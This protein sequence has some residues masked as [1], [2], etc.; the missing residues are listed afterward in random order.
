[1]VARL[2]GYPVQYNKAVV[3]RNAFAHEAGIHQHGVLEDRETYEIIDASTV[4]QE[5]AQIV[6]G[7]HSGRHAFADSLA[8][9]GLH[10]QGD[11]LNQAFTRFK[12]L[13]DRKVQITEA[14]LEAIVA[15]ELGVGVVHRY[16]IVSLEVRGG[17]VAQPSATVVLADEERGGKVE[18]DGSGNGMIDAAIEA[19]GKATGVSGTVLDFK[20]SS[21]TGGGDAL[22]DVVIQ[23]EVDGLKA[24]GR[25]CR[26]RRGGGL[27]ACLPEC[28]QQDRALARASRPAGEGRRA[29]TETVNLWTGVACERPRT[30]RPDPAPGRGLRGPAR[31]P[32]RG[33]SSRARPRH[34][35]RLAALVGAQRAPGRRRGGGRLLVDHARRGAGTVR[36]R[37]GD[38]AGRAR[39]RRDRCPTWARSTPF[40][41]F[42]IHH[43]VDARKRPCTARSTTVSRPAACSAISSTSRRPPPDS[44]RRSS[45]RS[46]GRPPTTIRRT[47]SRP[48]RRSSPGCATPASSTSTATGSGA[49]S[50]SSWQA[51]RPD[52][53]R[54]SL[55]WRVLGWAAWRRCAP[56]ALR[57]SCRCASRS[58]RSGHDR[59]Y[60]RAPPPHPPP[61]SPRRRLGHRPAHDARPW[62]TGSRR[63]AVPCAHRVAD[64][65]GGPVRA[66]GPTGRVDRGGVTSGSAPSSRSTASTSGSSRARRSASSARTAR[67]RRRPC[68]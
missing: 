15:E 50:R 17:T 54:R 18:A 20:V 59:V 33:T 5:A 31:V 19:I 56:T 14:D 21:V 37:A 10:V 32:A 6:L 42:A 51:N 29:M 57:T 61:P 62:S 39:P 68:A 44:T 8:K 30:A 16:T 45:W 36:R 67:A 9:M 28:G 25:G 53:A 23:L 12:E 24:S 66:G 26:H 38:H 47:S 11:A 58:I 49:S 40:S 46:A 3:G 35:R 63:R 60:R 43:V 4:G 27:G 55:A 1:M 13:A 7:K 64:R 48:S 52:A 41:A 34:R 22:G 65:L 2:T